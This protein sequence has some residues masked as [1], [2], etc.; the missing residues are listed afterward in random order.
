[1]LVVKA[2]ELIEK[3][4]MEEIAFHRRGWTWANNG[5]EEGFLEVRLDRLFGSAQWLLDHPAAIV[6]HVERQSSDHSLLILDTKP[7]QMRR[8]A[9]F[10]FDKR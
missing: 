9:R 4:E 7:E 10:Y 3:M 8:K 5:K 6:Q 1:M 2:R